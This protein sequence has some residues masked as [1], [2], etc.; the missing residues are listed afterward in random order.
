[1]VIAG[2]RRRDQ[3]DAPPPGD[4]IFMD[5]VVRTIVWIA[6]FGGT[7]AVILVTLPRV[8]IWCLEIVDTFQKARSQKKALNTP[9]TGP[10]ETPQSAPSRAQQL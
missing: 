9:H 5:H 4:G 2:R 6:L 3:R 7:G 8:V 1:M 10:Q